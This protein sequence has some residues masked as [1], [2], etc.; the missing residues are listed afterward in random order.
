MN[1]ARGPRQPEAVTNS[2]S[3]SRQ[4]ILDVAAGLFSSHGYAETGLG[5]TG[6][7]EEMRRG[8]ASLHFESKDRILGETLLPGVTQAASAARAAVEALP[9][10]ANP[11][12]RVEAAMGGHLRAVHQHI[13]YTSVN[14]KFRGQ[15]PASIGER[16]QP[17]RDEYTEYWRRLLESAKRAGYLRSDLRIPLLRSLM[18]SAMNGTVIW[19]RTDQGPI[20][21]L[22]D[23]TVAA[24]SGIWL[25]ERSLASKA[26]IPARRKSPRAARLSV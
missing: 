11:R 22:I 10:D 16:I 21:T 20:Q 1:R 25:K 23:T 14:I 6:A 3:A 13:I 24:F 7:R 26:H 5:E 15:M 12:D 19:F 9:A 17:L 8:S 2:N 4:L 18:L